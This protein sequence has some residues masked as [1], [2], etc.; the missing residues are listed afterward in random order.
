LTLPTWALLFALYAIPFG[1]GAW[2]S[3]QDKDLTSFVPASYVWFDNYRAELTA[4]E[5]RDALK[6]TLLITFLGLAIQI[7]IGTGLALLLAQP[8]RGSRM[9]RSALLVP[10]MLTPVAVGL[11]WRFMYDTDLGVINWF[12]TSTGLPRVNW[13]GDQT[14][15]LVSIVIVDSWQSIPF[16]MLLVLAGLL[17]LPVAPLEAASVDGATPWNRFFHIT[18]PMLRPVFYVVVLI[19]VIDAFKLF[20]IIFILTRGGPGTATQTLGM[21]TYN[22]GFNFLAISRAAALGIALAVISL[23]TYFLWL[24]AVRAATR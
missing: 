20:D 6:T 21:L 5:F 9:F 18:L 17:S 8:L 12:F 4:P 19:R 14:A 7:P 10:M 1:I 13:L 2:L 16:V 11:M 24:R 22:T 23:P 3:L 15:A